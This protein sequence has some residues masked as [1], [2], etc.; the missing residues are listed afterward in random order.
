MKVV[1]EPTCFPPSLPFRRVGV[2]AFGYG[3]TNGHAIIDNVESTVPNYKGHKHVHQSRSNSGSVPHGGSER[4]HLLVFSAHDKATLKRNLD[5]YSS[6]GDKVDLLD[7][8]YTLG[9]RR[10]KLSC[11]A[12]AVCRKQSY[13]TDLANASD[14]VIA[15]NEPTTVALLFTGNHALRHMR[16]DADV[17]RQA[18][19]HN[20]QE[21]ASS[22]SN[23][24]QP[25]CEQYGSLIT[26]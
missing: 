11:R 3:G 4:A 26:A 8:A 25:F 16:F 9:T 18:K 7:L 15:S 1:T 10:T 24:T 2:N 17:S 23:Y 12:F 13:S 21:W 6:I 5:S 20:G 22:Y 19:V 14:I